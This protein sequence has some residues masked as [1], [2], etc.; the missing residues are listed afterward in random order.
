MA[1]GISGI[2][3]GLPKGPLGPPKKL[4]IEPDIN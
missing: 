1:R 2:I 3:W 4:Y